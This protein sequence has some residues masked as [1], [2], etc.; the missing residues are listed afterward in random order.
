[1]IVTTS[2]TRVRCSHLLWT[3]E[4][5]LQVWG[6]SSKRLSQSRRTAMALFPSHPGNHHALFECFVS[7]TTV[8]AGKETICVV[9]AQAI[10]LECMV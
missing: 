3:F 10:T 5:H 9:V 1:M 7:P 2:M 8:M 6:S 4:T